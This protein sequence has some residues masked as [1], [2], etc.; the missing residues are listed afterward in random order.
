[1]GKGLHVN[2]FLILRIFLFTFMQNRKVNFTNFLESKN[3]G[4]QYLSYSSYLFI[5]LQAEPKSE[6]HQLVHVSIF[7]ILRIPLFAFMQN[8]KVN[9]TN[10]LDPKNTSSQDC[11]A[12]RKPPENN[13]WN[14]VKC[15]D[16]SHFCLACER[17]QRTIYKMRGIFTSLTYHRYRLFI[18]YMKISEILSNKQTNNLLLP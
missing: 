11:A 9:F 14:D 7:F 18:R 3:T 6:L 2:I 13:L 10:F 17:S 5:C 12:F 16:K 1:M 15:V 8:Q 4:R